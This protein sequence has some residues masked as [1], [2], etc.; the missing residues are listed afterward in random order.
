MTIGLAIA[1]PIV[2]FGSEHLWTG[3]T[4]SFASVN[5]P[6]SPSALDLRRCASGMPHARPPPIFDSARGPFPR[7]VILD[8]GAGP[9][10]HSICRR[11]RCVSSNPSRP[12]AGSA[13]PRA[14]KGSLGIG[15]VI[16]REHARF[17]GRGVSEVTPSRRDGVPVLR[18][19]G[20]R[21]FPPLHGCRDSGPGASVSRGLF[22]AVRHPDQAATRR[23]RNC[24]QDR[25]GMICSLSRLAVGKKRR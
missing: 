13:L 4:L 21:A 16:P 10:S 17:P 11:Y 18:H 1:R 24:P 3:V 5:T 8:D 25:V 22:S 12:S 6:A 9:P 23:S 20:S 2:C 7:E 15:D 14:S 19:A